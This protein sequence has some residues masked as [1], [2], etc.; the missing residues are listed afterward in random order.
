MKK[1]SL[2]LVAGILILSLV[3]TGCAAQTTTPVDT[4]STAVTAAPVAQD[5]TETASTETSSK[6]YKVAVINADISTPVFAFMEKMFALHAP[7]NNIE[8]VQFDGRGDTATQVQQ[9]L[10]CI[11]QGFDGVIIDPVDPAG[12]VPAC[13]K[14]MEAGIPLATF[15]SDLPKENEAD[16]T[17]CVT[18]D[19]YQAGVIAA[20]SFMEHFPDGTSIVEVGGMAGYDA[21]IKRHNGFRDTIEGSNI[22]VLDFQTCPTAWDAN[23][24]MDQMQNF[25]VKYGDQIQGIYCHWDGGLTGCFKALEAANMDATALF[26]L[27]IDGNQDGFQ[28][29]GSGL[30]DIS[31]MQNFDTM[32]NACL[33]LMAQAIQGQTVPSTTMPP[34]DIVTSET[35]NTFTAPEW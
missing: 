30:Q 27:G 29:V 14:V 31:L 18:A 10:D 20:Q 22:N 35:I 3:F 9:L 33:A 13:K 25:I 8:V 32:T 5:S 16:R 19:D 7:E 11:T 12:V 34:W 28:N 23:E 15:S 2:V 1:R 17:F 26:T 4:S 21:Q 24:A 6:M